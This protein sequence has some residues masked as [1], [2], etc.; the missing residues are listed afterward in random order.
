MRWMARASLTGCWPPDD[1]D[2]MI[3]Y[4]LHCEKDHGFESWFPDSAAYGT[5]VKRGLVSCPVCGSMRISKQIMAPSIRSSGK[6]RGEPEPESASG[7][8]AQVSAQAIHPEQP[9]ALMSEQAQK[10]RA[11]IRELHAHVKA[12]TEDVGHG[13][14]DEA[15][16][17][18]LGDKPERAIRGKASLEDAQAL[19]EEGIGVLPLPP[20]PDERN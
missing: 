18:H 20:L 10:M 14:A 17:M 1:A 4:A 11:M 5:Q 2:I 6:R 15:R 8:S 9:V 12:N 7:E 13:F 19:H 16:A 3:K